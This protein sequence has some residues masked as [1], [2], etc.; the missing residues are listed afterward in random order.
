LGVSS[1]GANEIIASIVSTVFILAGS[2]IVYQRI[3]RTV[4]DTI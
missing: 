2:V 3:E 1:V 4:M